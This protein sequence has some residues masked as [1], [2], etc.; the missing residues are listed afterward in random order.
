M[1]YKKIKYKKNGNLLSIS[2]LSQTIYQGKLLKFKKH[3]VT[4][5]ENLESCKQI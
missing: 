2:F 1:Q 5:T 4:L 3:L